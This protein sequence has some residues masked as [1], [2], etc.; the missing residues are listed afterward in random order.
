MENEEITIEKMWHWLIRQEAELMVPVKLSG[1]E[2]TQYHIENQRIIRAIIALVEQS[3]SLIKDNKI[4]EK[5]IVELSRQL[6]Y[7]TIQVNKNGGIR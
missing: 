2:P 1:K 4:L 3:S 7:L 5:H 6:D